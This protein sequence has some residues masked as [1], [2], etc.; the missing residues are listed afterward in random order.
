MKRF[1]EIEQ[2]SEEWF[3]IKWR[4][5]GGTLSKGLF[6]KS[7]TLLNDMVGQYLEE[8]EPTEGFSSF[9]M[10]YGKENEPFALEY[11][12]QYTGLKFTKTGWLQS[13]DNALLGISPDGITADNKVA[14]EI[15]CLQR[16][17]HTEILRTQEIPTEKMFQLLHYFTV[18]PDL[19][20]LY[21]I[22]FRPQ[23]K[24][25]IKKL[26]RDCVIDLGRKK[27]VEIEVIGKKGTPIKPKIEKHPDLKTVKEWVEIAKAEAN[28]LLEQI[29]NE[30]EK[31]NF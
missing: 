20:E 14:C 8:Y 26:T 13:D 21:F 31:V 22:S 19:E 2:G 4:K 3:N 12:E 29:K 17:A 18:N 25:F 28:T 10:E 16:I 9:D 1:D 6:I 7:D 15:K 27:D 23:S 24:H 11:L 30:V 5:I